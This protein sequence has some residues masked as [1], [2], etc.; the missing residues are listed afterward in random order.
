MMGTISHDGMHPF[1]LPPS[2]KVPSSLKG[3]DYERYMN[4]AINAGANKDDYDTAMINFDKALAEV[5]NS[6]DSEAKRAS[7]RGYKAAFLAKVAKGTDNKPYTFWLLVSG[8][9]GNGD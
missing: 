9:Y 3:T 5:Q 4:I 1:C 2:I 7:E 8:V 6:S